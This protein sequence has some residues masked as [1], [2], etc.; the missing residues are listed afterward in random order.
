MLTDQA[1]QIEGDVKAL[2][3]ARKHDRQRERFRSRR[4]KLQR[5]TRDIRPLA[6]TL[7]VFRAHGIAVEYEGEN[8]A[9]IIEEVEEIQKRYSEDPAWIIENDLSDLETWLDRHREKIDRRLRTAWQ[10]HYAVKVSTLSEDLL[11]TLAQFASF[12]EAVASVRRM[13]RQLEEQWRGQPPRTEQ[14]LEAFHAL[15]AERRETWE[16]I[17]FDE[18]VRDFIVS[19]GTEGAT[20]DQFTDEVRDWLKANGLFD[21]VRIRLEG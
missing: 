3:T 19:A 13:T 20:P 15:A 7:S 16:Q 21:Q 9:Q 17:Q 6:D 11:A 1:Q 12:Q 10:D 5:F 14:S 4:E 8:L 2:L 18:A